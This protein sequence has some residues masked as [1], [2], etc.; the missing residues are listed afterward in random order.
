[1]T[2]SELLDR[3]LRG[4]L[5]A[6]EALLARHEGPLLRFVARLHQGLGREA[7]REQARDTVQEVFLRLVREA[8]ALGGVVNLPAWLFR[9]ARNLALDEARREIRMERRHQLVASPEVLPPPPLAEERR[10]LSDVVTQ[11]LAALPPNQR[12][13]LVLK[14]Q[15][16]KSYREI[17]EITGLTTSNIGYLIHHGLKS[18][19]GQLRA[20]GVV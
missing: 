8:P 4:E 9:V 12:E 1:M 2:D 6:F 17:S 19:A 7:A 5:A 15:E 11:K 10:E 16:G 18:L 14:I 3:Y 13:V 20:A